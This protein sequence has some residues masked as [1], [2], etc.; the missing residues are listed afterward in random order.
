MSIS[1]QL[2]TNP[3]IF[4][5]SIHSST[6]FVTYFQTIIAL[7]KV[8]Y[9]CMILHLTNPKDNKLFPLPDHTLSL[10]VNC[11]SGQWG[12]E[13]NNYATCNNDWLEYHGELTLPGQK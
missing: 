11:S 10:F 12:K 13:Y 1:S 7:V 8:V 3:I 5:I 2:T 9:L 4:F 6:G